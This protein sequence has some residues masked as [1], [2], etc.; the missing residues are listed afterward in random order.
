VP[1]PML[2]VAPL[3]EL[4]ATP[5]KP[6]ATVLIEQSLAINDTHPDYAALLVA[7]HLLGGDA[8]SRLWSRIREKDGLSYDVRSGVSWNNFELNSSWRASA[9]FAPQ[10]RAKVEAALQEEVARALKDGF[11]QAELDAGRNGLLNQRRL[12][13]AQDGAVA[14]MLMGN[15]YLDRKFALQQKTESAIAALSLAQVN[16]ALVR[17]LDPK[18]WVLMFAGDFKP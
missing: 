18:Q 13:R 17:Y 14:G 5:G 7:N 15:L 9:I 1:Q 12:S 10:N 11:T 3:R 8:M 4:L 2:A 16:D 6:N